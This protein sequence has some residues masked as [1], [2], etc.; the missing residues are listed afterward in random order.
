MDWTST[1]QSTGRAPDAHEIAPGRHA[2]RAAAEGRE[3]HR[4]EAPQESRGGTRRRDPADDGRSVPEDLPLV[5]VLDRTEERA[6]RRRVRL[7]SIS[8]GAL[9]GV[10]AVALVAAGAIHLSARGTAIPLT[11]EAV[12]TST[13]A[14]ATTAPSAPSAAPTSASGN[15]PAVA[16]GT[17]GG[18]AADQSGQAPAGTVVVHVTGAVE[19]PGIVRLPAGS[20]IDDAVRAAGGARP[21]ADLSA[22]NLARPLGDG[23]QVHV[24]VPGE[25]P[26]APAGSS[27]GGVSPQAGGAGPAAS[28]AAG[29]GLVD[30]NTAGVAE[31][32]ALPGVGPAIAQRIVDHRDLNGPFASVDDLEQVSG[33]GPATL[34]KIRPLAT[35]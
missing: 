7:P 17:G 4:A 26:P 34:E 10:I 35:V 21:D 18:A 13:S 20:R 14:T 24:P 33:I 12:P 6:R 32:D 22:V 25:S 11:A 9:L 31:L 30:L 29:G 8:R 15:T 28:D 16:V 19:A 2:R 27:S 1:E 3:G 5:T 23:E